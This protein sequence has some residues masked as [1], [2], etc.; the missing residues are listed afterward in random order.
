MSEAQSL[1]RSVYLL[2]RLALITTPWV[3]QLFVADICLSLLLPLSTI[4]PTLS[5]DLSSGIAESVWRGIQTIFTRAN[6][7]SITISGP[8]LPKGESAIVISNHVEWTD[9]Y[10]I[11]ALALRA[12]MLG[13][14][15]W[16]AKQQLKWVPFLGWGLWAMGM[17]LVSRNWTL[18]VK[19]MDRV[20]HGVLS[21]QWPICAW[22]LLAVCVSLYF[23]V[24][25]QARDPD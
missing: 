20:F 8:E 10:M 23:V 22:L 21:E 5:Y 24:Y 3:A 17:P 4:F 12:G 13:R 1:A 9:V 18:D 14:C 6:G 11:Q 2:L 15:R 7:A 16:F 25:L 19:E